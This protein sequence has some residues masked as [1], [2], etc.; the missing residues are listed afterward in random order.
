MAPFPKHDSR[1]GE[2]VMLRQRVEDLERTVRHVR[3][4]ADAERQRADAAEEATRRAYQVAI[5]R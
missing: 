4:L 1:W 3:Q 2:V 5:T